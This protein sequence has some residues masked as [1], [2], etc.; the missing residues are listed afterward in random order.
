[1]NLDYDEL[2]SSQAHVE[3]ETLW[4]LAEFPPEL[5][6]EGAEKEL[7]SMNEFGVYRL[8]PFSHTTS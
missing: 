5:V 6:N 1:M 8:V 2:E 4:L 7:A 3:L